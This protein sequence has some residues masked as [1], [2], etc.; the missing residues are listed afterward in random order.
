MLRSSHDRYEAQVDYFKDMNLNAI[1]LEGNIA[2]DLDYLLD[3]FD[4]AGILVLLGWDCGWEH[5][6]SYNW[7][8]DCLIH[9]GSKYR[10]SNNMDLA[11]AYTRDQIQRYR[12][13]PSFI[14][15]LVGSDFSVPT[16]LEKDEIELFDR[17]DGTR[18]VISYAT[19]KGDKTT[20][21][22]D[23]GWRMN[24]PY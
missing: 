15:W 7:E 17:Y 19:G 21:A 4:E 1:R 23:P 16:K 24:G 10:I 18:P 14:C 5:G 9:G 12:N 11:L 8:K 22:G 2:G 6:T 3:L 20:P 13:H